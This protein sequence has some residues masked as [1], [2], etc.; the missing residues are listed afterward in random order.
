MQAMAIL[1]A[2][3]PFRILLLLSIWLSLTSA[4][5][6]RKSEHPQTHEIVTNEQLVMSAVTDFNI[7]LNYIQ[8]SSP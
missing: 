7:N 3:F 2:P 4:V 1:F 5:D 8:I 6:I